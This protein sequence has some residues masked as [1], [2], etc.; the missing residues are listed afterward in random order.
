MADSAATHQDSEIKLDRSDFPYITFLLISVAALVLRVALL[1]RT[2]LDLIDHFVPW[3][4]DIRT[5][6]FWVAV[7]RPFSAYGYTPFYSYCIGLADAIFP[8]GTDGKVV[9]KSVSIVFDFIAAGLVYALAK[10]CWP[11]RRN[12]AVAGYTALLFAP[13]VVLN[14]AFWGQSDIVYTSFQLACLYALLKREPVW[15]MIWFGVAVAIKLQAAWLGP[16]ILM[17]VLRGQI[18]WWLLGLVPLVYLLMS[19]PAVLAG[20]PLYEVGTIYLTQ[21]GTQDSLNYGAANLQ[22]FPQY[23]FVHMGRWPE[24]VPLFAKVSVVFT[25]LLGLWFAWRAS[26][27]KLTRDQLLLAALASVLIAPQF[28]PYMHNRYFFSADVFTILLALWR[29]SWWPAALMMQASSFVTYISFLWPWLPDVPVPQWL[30][31]FGFTNNLQPVTGLIALA[32]IANAI[33]LMWCWQKLKSNAI[34]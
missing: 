5:R 15:A 13:T 12:V 22:F 23:Y 28:L 29:S 31:V 11:E 18:R 30:F 6:G 4:E 34:A 16:F 27:S 24:I 7:A 3:L 32:G 10:L 9:I 2:N 26:R 25:A 21:A 17:M 19:L 1:D 8:A 20:R 14:G 33:L